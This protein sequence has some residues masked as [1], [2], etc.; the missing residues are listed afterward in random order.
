[1][2]RFIALRIITTNL[3]DIGDDAIEVVLR[4]IDNQAFAGHRNLS[5][6]GEFRLGLYLVT[7]VLPRPAARRTATVIGLLNFATWLGHDK[8][9]QC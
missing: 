3:L 4:K 8:L 5:L 1:L 7:T 9:L 2:L 6:G